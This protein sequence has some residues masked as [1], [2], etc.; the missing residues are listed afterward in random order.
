MQGAGKILTTN[1][2]TIPGRV[3]AYNATAMKL[4]SDITFTKNGYGVR[5]ALYYTNCFDAN[6]YKVT[7]NGGA[8]AS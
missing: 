6:G 1:G 3:S 4:G 8:V 2:V 5:I 7:I